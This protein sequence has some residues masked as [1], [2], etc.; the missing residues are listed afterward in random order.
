MS[1]QKGTTTSSLTLSGS[2]SF[3]TAQS[4]DH[5]DHEGLEGVQLVG[6]EATL[7]ADHAAVHGAIAPVEHCHT[8]AQ[9]V[10]Q[11]DA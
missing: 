9:L 5:G 4:V 1:S 6:A 7:T 2:S 11:H 3:W 8:F 10:V